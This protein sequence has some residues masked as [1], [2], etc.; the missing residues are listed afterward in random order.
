MTSEG[1]ITVFDVANWFLSKQSMTH[2]KLQK[3][4]YYAQAWHL[5][6]LNRRLFDDEFQAWVHGPVNRNLYD[7]Y[8]EFGWTLIP[9]TENNNNLFSNDS[10]EILEN[11]YFTYGNQTA[12]ELEYMTH[13][14]KPW[15]EARGNLGEWDNSQTVI[16]EKT[17][18][19]YYKSV[20]VGD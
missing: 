20:Y 17:M 7:K 4:C 9:M 11:V 6:L 15:L 10:L 2:K 14:E 13:Q 12:G 16:N 8:T 19:N 3:L 18:K 5:A 1:G